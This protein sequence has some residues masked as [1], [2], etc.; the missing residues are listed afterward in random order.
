MCLVVRLKGK[1]PAA[2]GSEGLKNDNMISS[3]KLRACKDLP[4]ERQCSRLAP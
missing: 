4:E 1:A 3:G 2:M